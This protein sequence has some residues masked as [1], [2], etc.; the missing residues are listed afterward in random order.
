M[1]IVFN[2]KWIKIFENEN[3]D[4]S[5][6][7]ITHE[8]NKVAVLPYHIQDNGKPLIVYLKE[9]LK[10]WGNKAEYTCVTGTIEKNEE[11]FPAA[12]R[13][14]E[15]ETGIEINEDENWSY[16]GSFNKS[17][18]STC[19]VH[20]YLVDIEKAKPIK[21]RTDGS[22][23][24]KNTRVMYSS[25]VVKLM[26]NDIILQFLILNLNNKIKDNA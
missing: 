20:C 16:V 17:K 22:Y 23:F 4:G 2:N 3:P 25:D 19:L 7:Y 14:L 15:E 6:Y 11:H 5:K 13:E 12:K 21:R 1:K 10:N 8:N 24:E 9:P 18:G 26:T